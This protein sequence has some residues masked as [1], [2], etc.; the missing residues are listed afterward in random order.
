MRVL[1][2]KWEQNII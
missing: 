2:A 1:L